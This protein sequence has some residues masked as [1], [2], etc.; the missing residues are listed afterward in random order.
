MSKCWLKLI[1][2]KL[3][4]YES[5]SSK[6][7]ALYYVDI[8]R[9]QSI[10]FISVRINNINTCY[11]YQQCFNVK[12][13]LLTLNCIVFFPEYFRSGKVDCST[14]SLRARG[15]QPFYAAGHILFSTN[16]AGRV[17]SKN[18]YFTIYYFLVFYSYRIF[19]NFFD[20]LMLK[21]WP[22]AV[23][24]FHLLQSYT[25]WAGPSRVEGEHNTTRRDDP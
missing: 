4:R 22:I 16:L 12:Y 19:S 21:R 17:S 2:I 10:V 24:I 20:V 25:S 1:K 23:L 11:I 5:V 15:L 18:M 9:Y 3:L 13:F 7:T 6:Y 14:A 8:L